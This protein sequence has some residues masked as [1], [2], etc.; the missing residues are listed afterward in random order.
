MSGSYY[1][2]THSPLVDIHRNPHILQ[3]TV[4][5][6]GDGL[7]ASRTNQGG[8][9][10]RWTSFGSQSPNVLF[11]SQDPVAIDSVMYD[12]LAAETTLYN[13]SDDYLALA[14]QQGLGVFEHAV[15]GTYRR[16]VY[17][18]F[19]L[20]APGGALTYGAAK[21][22]SGGVLPAIAGVGPFTIGGQAT[23]NVTGGVG[24]TWGVLLLGAAADSLVLPGGTVLVSQIL[25]PLSFTLGGAPGVPGAG[26]ASIQIPIPRDVLLVGR[27]F[28]F[29]AIIA[30][31]GAPMGISHTEGLKVTVGL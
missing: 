23:I 2:S 14:E 5:V 9:P 8:T 22:G 10:T 30:D 7:F 28:F 4:L 15:G 26:S 1:I 6:I 31:A 11:F 3:K 13:H 20:G 25:I 18:P 24:G 19:D 21:P 29:Q 17:R 27:E 16:I 12:H